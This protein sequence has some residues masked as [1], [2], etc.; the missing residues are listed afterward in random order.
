MHL[1]RI[2]SQLPPLILNQ[3]GQSTQRNI[4]GFLK[5]K[6]KGHRFASARAVST[7]ASVI[8]IAIAITEDRAEGERW[9]RRNLLARV[10]LDS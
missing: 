7:A 4:L 6:Q 9:R 1:L 8:A 3:P 5:H 10:D 2:R